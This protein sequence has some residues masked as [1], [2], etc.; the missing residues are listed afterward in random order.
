MKQFYV[1]MA[2]AFAFPNLSSAQYSADN[3]TAASSLFKGEMTTPRS[4][5]WEKE[6]DQINGRINKIQLSKMRSVTDAIVSFFHDSCISD[7]PVAPVWHGEYSS[8]KTSAQIKYGVFCNFYEQKARLTVLANDMSM[9]LDH[10]VVNNHD[11]LTL[12]ASTATKNDCTYFEYDNNKIWLVTTGNN[13][14]PYIPVTRKEYLQEATQELTASKNSIAADWKQ[15]TPVRSAAIQEAE[16]KALLEQLSAQYSGMDLQIRTRMLLRDYKT[17]EEYLTE[18]TNKAT[19]DLD[20]TLHIMESI[21]KHL[22]P[23]ELAKPAFVSVPA[24][25]F[26]GFE[27]GQTNKM[28]VRMNPIYFDLTL[29]AEKPQLFLVCWHFDSSDAAAADIDRQL[30]GHLDGQKLRE[31]LGK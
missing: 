3:S 7:A 13:Q 29:G 24:A 9:L 30:L 10:L 20:S 6:K 18:N 19:A 22:S 25:E 2:L 11:L 28:L 27:D 12:R 21:L 4:Q 31:M 5:Q 15:K 1:M 16:K 26:Q 14:L 8:E 23:T 17:D